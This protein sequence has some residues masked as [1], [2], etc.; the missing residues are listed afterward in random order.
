MDRATRVGA[1]LFLAATGV[2]RAQG[3][4][5]DEPRAPAFPVAVALH[6]QAGWNGARALRTYGVGNPDPL[7]PACDS[8]AARCQTVHG[9]S[10][11]AGVTVRLQLPLSQRVGL[12][13]GLS[14][15]GPKPRV[16]LLDGSQ[17]R[18]GSGGV[19]TLRGEAL[20]LF[21]LK[22]RVPVFFGVGGALARQN[23]GPAPGQDTG[24]EYGGVVAVGFDHRMNE[25]LGLRVE[26][27]GFFLIPDQIPGTSEY[28]A[29]SFAFDH[30]L[31]VGVNY[32]VRRTRP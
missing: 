7:D 20:L 15:S 26:W 3:F 25:Q 28:E 1:L 18:I 4:P 29:K 14:Y 2:V 12:R 6:V 24:V 17:V 11:A 21:R 9:L 16:E 13:A 8:V 30:Q 23:P 10:G 22:P 32:F 5:G 27:N 31:S 19:K